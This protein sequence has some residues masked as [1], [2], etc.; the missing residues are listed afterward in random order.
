MILWSWCTIGVFR[1]VYRHCGVIEGVTPL[2]Q[3]QV[4]HAGLQLLLRGTLSRPST[5]LVGV[6]SGRCRCCSSP[7]CAAAQPAAR[8]PV[9]AE[10]LLSGSR[11]AQGGHSVRWRRRCLRPG[12]PGRKWT[13][14]SHWCNLGSI[15]AKAR[16]V[17]WGHTELTFDTPWGAADR[18]EKAILK[19]LWTV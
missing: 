15:I 12:T 19:R 11:A 13:M 6:D 17:K 7:W 8:E 4:H 14:S 16:A 9:S 10:H 2:P 5:D 1:V 3:Q 18:I